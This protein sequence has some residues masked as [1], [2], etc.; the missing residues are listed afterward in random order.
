MNSSIIGFARRVSGRMPAR[1]DLDPLKVPRLLP[2]IGLID[3]KNGLGDASF[4]L[5]GTR[6]H[7][8]YGEEI[9][10]KRAGEV[11]SGDQA[12]YWHRVHASLMAKGLPLQRRGARAGSRPRPYR[13]V[14]V[15]IAVVGG[16]RPGGSHPLLRRGGARGRAGSA[17]TGPVLLFT[18]AAEAV[19]ASRAIRLS[20]ESA[21]RRKLSLIGTDQ[22]EMPVEVIAPMA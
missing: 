20:L 6:L 18:H 14:L 2:H 8:I 21:Q 9:T 3:L 7:D 5:A 16:W 11:F 17:R 19:G 1:S 13:V 12:D 22:A 4:R 15:E 10:G